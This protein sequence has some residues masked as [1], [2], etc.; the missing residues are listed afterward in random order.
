VVVARAR[1][2]EADVAGKNKRSGTAAAQRGAYRNPTAG[3]R[4]DGAAGVKG[5]SKGVR[6][7]FGIQD[8]KQQAAGAAA[9]RQ[10]RW[11]EAAQGEKNKK[12]LRNASA[13]ARKAW[14]TRRAKGK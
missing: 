1:R 13:A 10:R 8:A 12:R 9:D 4:A 6:A 3:A 7:A 2:E 5:Q 14:Q 11:N